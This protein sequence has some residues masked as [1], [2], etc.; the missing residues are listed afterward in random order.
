MASP[1]V[2]RLLLSFWRALPVG[3]RS[4]ALVLLAGRG[5]PR[6]KG[7]P[8]AD[9]PVYVAGHLSAAT[10]LGQSARLYF[11]QARAA[12]CV[13]HAVDLTEKLLQQPVPGVF[14]RETL[15]PAEF[16]AHTGPG[17][18]VIHV[19]PPVF[20][21]ALKH[22]LPLLPGKRVVAY[23]A[24]E[25]MDIPGFWRPCL[26]FADAVEAPSSFTAAA[27]RPHT[28]KPVTVHP[29]A[30]PEAATGDRRFAEDGMVRVLTMFDMASNFH[31]KNP[32]AAV[33]AFQLA[34]GRDP[35][36]RLLIKTS[37]VD[38]YP[39]GRQALLAA[40]RDW[41]NITVHDQRLSPDALAALYYGHDIALS[42]HRSEGYGL[43]IQEA[44]RH[45]LHAVATGWSGNMD[46]MT[47]GDR[48]HPVPYAMTPVRD[49]QGGMSVSGQSWAEADTAAAAAI[50][51][52][53]T[54]AE[55]PDL[56]IPTPPDCPPP[57]PR[58]HPGN[59]G[60]VLVNYKGWP[61]TL[62]ALEAL[63]ALRP[64]RIVVVDNCS[65]D[66]SVPQLLAGWE[67]LNR[68]AGRAAPALYDEAGPVPGGDLLLPL[69]E[70]NGFAAGNNAALRLLLLDE[71]CLAFWLLNN[72][73]LP[74]PEALEALCQR[75]NTRPDAGLCG[76]LLVDLRDPDRVQCAGGGTLSRWTGVTRDLNRGTSASRVQ[77]LLPEAVEQR[78]AF[79]TAASL[80]IRRE[81]LEEVGL[82]SEDYFLYYEDTD[83]SLRV[84]RSGYALAFAPQS[85]VLHR[86]GA[87]T[88]QL[89]P[90]VDYLSLRNRLWFMRRHYPARLAF[91]VARHLGTLAKR[92]LAGDLSGGLRVVQ[93]LLDRPS[94]AGRG[95]RA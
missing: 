63:V 39:P 54:H 4:R 8:P 79:L 14:T 40:T 91:A 81:A 11:E 29:H 72:D 17:T 19:N 1:A 88:G 18:L 58:L 37:S 68:Q 77:A 48:C 35:R 36:A 51:R 41:E 71:D 46:F 5:L 53:I 94:R 69:R 90:L 85:V 74:R 78:L 45:G 65:R 9:G 15:S 67:A 31:R 38:R 33:R 12:G 82:L 56:D 87:S 32:L 7:L 62:A 23:W 75:L 52:G 13:V 43:T 95:A 20:M 25:L 30:V 42:L 21:L 34:F 66:D 86:E 6:A 70:N 44:L 55:R 61:D 27:I 47:Q 57:R 59:T 80:L 89:R 22:L 28:A 93:A 84:R 3:L 92:L 60:V 50:L 76:S 10:G 83:L 2:K 73:A 49:D 16:H 24:W 64:G 26:A